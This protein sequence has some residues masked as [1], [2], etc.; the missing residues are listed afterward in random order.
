MGIM[1]KYTTLATLK[2]FL[3]ITGTDQDAALQELIDTGTDLL[4]LDLGEN[5]GQVTKTRRVDGTGTNR[6]FLEREPS[7]VSSMSSTTDGGYSWSGI[8]LEADPIEGYAV[9]AATIIPKGTR[10][11]KVTYTVGYSSVPAD[12]EEFFL[13][14]VRTLKTTREAIA[15]GKDPFQ[16]VKSKKIEG[17]Q[18]T[19][20]SPSELSD[21]LGQSD[22]FAPLYQN[23]VNKYRVFNFYTTR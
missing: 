16:K 4:D 3:G 5:L 9:F 12:L 23:I 8:D 1:L 7:A 17:L 6:I 14:Y 19:Y 11:I 10:N 18:V 2:T 15:A 13:N 21:G 20:F 22:P